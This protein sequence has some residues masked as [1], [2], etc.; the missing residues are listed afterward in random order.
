MSKGKILI[1]GGM[2]ML[3]H[4][5]IQEF[6]ADFD[7]S[8]TIRSRKKDVEKLDFVNK[9]EVFESIDVE[10]ILRVEQVINKARP[11][12][13]INAV[14]IIKQL[15]E[16][17]NDLLSL[18]INSIFPRRLAQL[19]EKYDFRLINI[20]TDCVFSGEKGNYSEN[21]FAD[22]EDLY[23]K[24]KLLGETSGKNSLTIRT[25]IIGRELFTNHS[26]LEWF[27][28]N[29]KNTVKGFTKAVFSGFPTLILSEIIKEIITNYPKLE[30]LY[31]ISS[32]PISKYDLLCLIKEK[33]NLSVEIKPFDDFKIDRSLDSAKFRKLTGFVPTAW[34][35]MIE[36][37]A[38]DPT[39]YDKWRK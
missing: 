29:Q 28:F 20:S 30:G 36:R 23:G 9:A 31:H 19:S 27:L 37:M 14:G 7:V 17:K 34:G 35:K 24:S 18:N 5:L 11:G 13:V 26:L 25:S 33:Y 32:Q 39:P 6:S 10:D 4:K 21:D 16:S 15:P 12:V 1:F 22:A 38:F 8:F 2:G 3:G